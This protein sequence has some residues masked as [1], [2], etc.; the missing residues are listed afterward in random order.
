MKL[1]ENSNFDKTFMAGNK[2]TLF[3]SLIILILLP[4][5]IYFKSLNNQITNWDDNSYITSNPDIRTLNGDSV[6]V[7]LKKTFSGY[8]LGNYHPLTMLTFC[9]EYNAFK[10]NAK[11]YHVVNLMIHLLNTLLVFY[12]TWLLSKKQLIAFITALLFAIH[13][14]HVESVSWVSELKDVLYTFFFLTGL[15]TYTLFIQKQKWSFYFIALFLFLLSTLSKGMAVSFPLVLFVIDYFYDKKMTLGSV[16]EKA[17]FLLVSVFFGI[18]AIFA[19]KH[20]KAIDIQEYNFFERVLFSCYGLLTY[21]WKLILPINLSCYYPYPEKKEG[22]YP[23]FFYISPFIIFAISILIYKSKKMGKSISFGFGFFAATIVLVLQILPVGSAII[24]ERYTYVP[25]VGL[26]FVIATGVNYLYESNTEKSKQF[27]GLSLVILSFFIIWYSYLTFQRTKVWHDTI[28]LWTDVIKKYRENPLAYNNRAETYFWNGDYDRAIAD[29]NTAI[30]LGIE[31]S[32]VFYKRGYS[33]FSAKK[34]SEA[35]DDFNRAIQLSD[36]SPIVYY[37]RAYAYSE[38]GKFNE[39][40]SDYNYVLKRQPDFS[41]AYHD[42]GLTYYKM[43]R[44][45]DAIVNFDKAIALTPDYATAYLSRGSA[46]LI[47]G[48]AT[49]AIN[50]YTL[51]I[52]YNLNYAEAF[53]NRAIANLSVKNYEFALK[54]ALKAKELGYNIPPIW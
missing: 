40:I 43:G 22:L 49:D 42:R 35:L 1:E 7:T 27:K 4:T 23:M 39:A 32:S 3:V 19:Q 26:F 37:K 18:I 48:N 25:Y 53:Y 24:S 52:K 45:N 2:N 6:G 46:L 5:I 31:N 51:A 34:Y 54:D 21:L 17:P 15:C 41:E 29:F 11:P 30:Q 12:F 28:T 20:G 9:L 50:N 36:A 38:L 44:Y 16:V 33:F 8:V 14:M 10:L 47:Q 13:P